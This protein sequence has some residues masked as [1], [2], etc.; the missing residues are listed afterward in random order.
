M[1]A[2]KKT[3]PAGIL[4]ASAAACLLLLLFW[5]CIQL[6]VARFYYQRGVDELAGGRPAAAHRALD[7]AF[8]AMPGAGIGDPANVDRHRFM[9]F[10]GDWQ[11]LDRAYG[12]LYL[13]KAATAGQARMFFAEMIQAEKFY[14]AAIALDPGDIGA[15]RGLAQALAGLEKITKHLRTDGYPPR[16][17]GV[18]FEKLLQLRPRGIEAHWLFLHY[19]HGIG[20]EEKMMS[21]VVRL[22]ALYPRIYYQLQKK[23]FF[24]PAM[25]TAVEHGLQEALA[26]A[27]LSAEANKVLAD[28]VSHQGHSAQAVDYYSRSFTQGPDDRLQSDYLRMGELYLK[29]GQLENAGTVFLSAL[30]QNRAQDSVLRQIWARYRTAGQFQAFVEFCGA[31]ETAMVFSALS[32]IGELLLAYCRLEMGQDDLARG[33]LAQITERRYQAEGYALQAKLAARVKDW[34]E[35][36]VAAHQATVLEPANDGYHRLF[37]EALKKQK[38]L[39]AAERAAT[40]A[41]DV[42]T[43]PNPFRYSSRAWI[44]MSLQDYPGAEED[45]QYSV[46]LA[47]HRPEFV[48][49]LAL[50]AEKKLD[51]PSALRQARLALQLAPDN[52]QYQEKVKALHSILHGGR[53]GARS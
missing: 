43:A 3:G 14:R 27:R 36:E 33:H 40:R 21:V 29:N 13:Q 25:E 26:S 46:R 48:Y 44:R 52:R 38:K 7:Q 51:Y 20:D 50:V 5:V 49:Y 30:L 15:A 34:D 4:L 47:P 6:F 23:P 42:A 39:D 28:L 10:N 24:S 45:W 37:I 2:V 1:E 12:D 8:A 16:S 18:Y 17:A 32:G 9:L 22:V 35:M 19:L 53:Q 11:R 41:I 31:A